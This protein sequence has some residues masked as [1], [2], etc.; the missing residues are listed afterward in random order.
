MDRIIWILHVIIS[1][2]LDGMTTTITTTTTTQ[3]YGD[4][5]LGTSSGAENTG[6]LLG[7]GRSSDVN[8]IMQTGKLAGNGFSGLIMGVGTIGESKENSGNRAEGFAYSVS[9]QSY[10]ND[11]GME[12]LV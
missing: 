12:D 4:L 11:S 3:Q 6:V 7:V 8:Y 5:N 10:Q 9:S 2:A 1:S